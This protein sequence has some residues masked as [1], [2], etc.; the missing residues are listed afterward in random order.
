MHW[1]APWHISL[2]QDI[3]LLGNLQ[4]DELLCAASHVLPSHVCHTCR[5]CQHNTL[6]QAQRLMRGAG[7]L[8]EREAILVS[9]EVRAAAAQHSVQTRPVQLTGKLSFWTSSTPS[10][11]PQT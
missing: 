7:M 11:P 2:Q 10:V 4:A 9:G 6:A 3:V 1:H 5:A 8:T